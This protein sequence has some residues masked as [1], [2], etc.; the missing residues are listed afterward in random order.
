MILMPK[1]NK[2]DTFQEVFALLMA[3][4]DSVV[5]MITKKLPC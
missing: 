2:F 1:W 5:V 3:L 4:F